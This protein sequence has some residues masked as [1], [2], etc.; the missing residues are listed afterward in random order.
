MGSEGI[1]ARIL[2]LGTIC[3]WCYVPGSFAPGEKAPL[4]TV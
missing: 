2:N 4:H 1:A 3:E